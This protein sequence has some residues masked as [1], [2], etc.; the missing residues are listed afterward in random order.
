MKSIPETANSNLNRLLTQKDED[1]D[2]SID[3]K[4]EKHDYY[5]SLK[6]K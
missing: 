6:D 2:D 4:F 1:S 3:K 5:Q